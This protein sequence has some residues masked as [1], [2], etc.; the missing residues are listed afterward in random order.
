VSRSRRDGS[1]KR[2]QVIEPG[3]AFLRAKSQRSI[4]A[5]QTGASP[6]GSGTPAGIS[7]D[8]VSGPSSARWNEHSSVRIA[9][10]LWRATTRRVVKERPLRTRSTS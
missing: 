10:A 4:P 3:S 9:P 8:C 2:A 6:A 1:G 5:S 7:A